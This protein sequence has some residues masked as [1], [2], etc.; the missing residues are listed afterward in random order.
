MRAALYRVLILAGVF[1]VS[2]IASD[3]NLRNVDGHKIL[4]SLQRGTVA[5]TRP[6]GI[7]D[8]SRLKKEV[9]LR[10]TPICIL[11]FEACKLHLLSTDATNLSN[12]LL[13]ELKIV[14]HVGRIIELLTQVN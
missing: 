13:F 7:K 2:L 12:A 6:F 1:L 8:E 3:R 14:K 10:L 9:D 5:R 11:L 4:H